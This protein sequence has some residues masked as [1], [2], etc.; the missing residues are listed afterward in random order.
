MYYNSPARAPRVNSLSESAVR[1]FKSSFRKTVH[2]KKLSYDAFSTLALE[3][4]SSLNQRPLFTIR[5][6]DTDTFSDVLTPSKLLFG[7]NLELFPTPQT[8][9][10][11]EKDPNY[12]F[13]TTGKDLET[14]WQNRLSLTNRFLQVYHNMYIQHLNE[15]HFL[16]KQYIT[17]NAYNPDVGDVVF[18]KIDTEQKQRSKLRYGRIIRKLD[19][20]DS[21]TRG[22]ELIT[23]DPSCKCLL[24]PAF[25]CKTNKITRTADMLIPLECGS[26][27][28][29]PPNLIPSS[30]MKAP[31]IE[32]QQSEIR[33]QRPQRA[34]KANAKVRI[35]NQ[36]NES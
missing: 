25:K 1:I 3:A 19:S 28:D 22:Y 15:I 7:R 24:R 18:F 35:R 27:I 4:C 14:I 30:K 36:M 33:A 9:V 6:H 29:N 16:K 31:S 21:R 34:A 20:F 11:L 32:Q 2:R 13:K 12:F 23:H 10:D 26:S 8:E 17:N 5:S